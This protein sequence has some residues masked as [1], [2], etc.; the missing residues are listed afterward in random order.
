[1]ADALRASNYKNGLLS[2]AAGPTIGSVGGFAEAAIKVP[3]D[4]GRALAGEVVA[5]GVPLFAIPLPGIIG[6]VMPALGQ[7]FKQDIKTAGKTKKNKR[8]R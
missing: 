5:H 3:Q 1:M 4:K 7:R 2:F 8:R 6:G